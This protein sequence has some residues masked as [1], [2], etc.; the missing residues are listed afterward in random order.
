MRIARRS[1]LTGLAVAL[2]LGA[3]S[4]CTPAPASAAALPAPAIDA[5]RGGG[6]Q[7]VVLS[8]GCFWGIQ[9]VFQ[10]V[11]GVKS[12]VS[13]YA[14]G[15]AATADYETVSTGT[16][17]HAES[18]RIVFDPSQVSFGTLLRIFFSVGTDPTQLNHQ[19]PDEGPQYR[20]EIWFTNADQQRV[21]NAYI[22][23]LDKAHAFR[24]RIVTRVEPL[25]GFYA[26][27]AYHQ[28]Y[29]TLHPDSGYIARYDLPKV[30]QLKRDFPAYYRAD[31]VLVG[32]RK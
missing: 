22:A 23:Q 6:D 20:N 7:V 28:D 31:P 13:G 27:E 29:L 4:A 24:D 10:H 17:G 32:R 15:T 26:A 2:A 25:K 1:L 21:A 30:A 8:G 14:G 19:F 5:P 16:T 3:A 9:G 11:K 18:V 12:A